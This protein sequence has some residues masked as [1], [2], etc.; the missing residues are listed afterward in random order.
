[1]PEPFS[2]A[3]R[4]WIPVASANGQRAFVRLCD[5][6][7]PHPLDGKPIERLATGRADCD[8]ALAEF[9]IGLLAVAIGPDRSE[10]RRVGKECRL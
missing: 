4:A 1:M 5:L 8:T 9:L 10:E 7:S 2:L 3:G 6:T